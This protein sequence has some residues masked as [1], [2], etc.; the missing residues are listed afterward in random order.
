[1][2]DVSIIFWK[3]HYAPI[4]CACQ[5][6]LPCSLQSLL[7]ILIKSLRPLREIAGQN[8]KYAVYFMY[9]GFR[10]AILASSRN[11]LPIR[12]L[13]KLRVLAVHMYISL[14]CI[15]YVS[16][17]NFKKLSLVHSNASYFFSRLCKIITSII[18]IIFSRNPAMRKYYNL[19][20][21]LKYT[22]LEY[23]E[24]NIY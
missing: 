8:M 13:V 9:F 15:S 10:T 2:I 6:Y 16:K 19:A 7:R 20:V 14:N 24:K 17:L 18:H 22:H 5:C 3:W 1:M 4:T 23:Y 12:E 11:D 21:F